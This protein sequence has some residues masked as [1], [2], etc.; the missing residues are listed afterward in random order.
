MPDLN[1]H[2]NSEFGN[3]YY[4]EVEDSFNENLS[5]EASYFV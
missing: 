2:D 3:S 4:A 5:Q 1:D